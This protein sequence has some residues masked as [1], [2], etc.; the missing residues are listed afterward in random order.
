MARTTTFAVLKAEVRKRADVESA[1]ERHP[2]SDVGRYINQGGAALRE[3][4]IEAK[5]RTYFRKSPA[6]LIT[7]DGVNTRFTLP[8]D[9][10]RLISIRV[11]GINGYALNR[12]S[13]QDEPGLRAIPSAAWPTHYELQPT[14]IEILPLPLAGLTLTLD[15]IP[16]YADLV[17]D[18][19][20]LEGFNGHE[21]YVVMFAARCIAVKDEEWDLVRSLDSDLKMMT[22]RIEKLAPGRDAFR[23]E[24]VKD[25]RGTRPFFRRRGF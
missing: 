8:T 16:A 12:F 5:G 14:T 15:Y 6:P 17:A 10:L 13:Q 11:N 1:D 25:V 18:D 20:P 24:T 2:D 22:T 7:T 4:Y 9:F 3:L 23:A 19:D 21:E